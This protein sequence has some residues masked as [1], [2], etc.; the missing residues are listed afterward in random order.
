MTLQTTEEGGNW[1]SLNWLLEWDR[2]QQQSV[3]LWLVPDAVVMEEAFV[4]QS[5]PSQS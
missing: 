1:G 5:E 3:Q 4:H 2:H